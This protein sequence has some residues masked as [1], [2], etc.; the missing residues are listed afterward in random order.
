LL[1]RAADPAA[2][3]RLVRTNWIRTIGWSARGVVAVAVLV[4]AIR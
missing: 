1:S 3:R 4:A 2:M